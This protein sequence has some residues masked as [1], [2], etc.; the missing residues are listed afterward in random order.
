MIILRIAEPYRVFSYKMYAEIMSKDGA[1]YN[2]IDYT[3]V[4][5]TTE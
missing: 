3:Y 4:H 2:Y 1:I 5:S